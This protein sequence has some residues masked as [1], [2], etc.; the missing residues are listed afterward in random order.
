MKIINFSFLKR[1]GMRLWRHLSGFFSAVS[2][3]G[4]VVILTKFIMALTLRYLNM[5]LEVGFRLYL[6]KK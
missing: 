2:Q 6:K 1:D 3:N 4:R 5:N